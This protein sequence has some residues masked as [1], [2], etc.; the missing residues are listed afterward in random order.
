MF[1]LGE[2]NSLVATEERGDGREGRGSLGLLREVAIGSLGLLRE[3]SLGLLREVE[4][5]G[6]SLLVGTVDELLG[7]SLALPVED[8]VVGDKL[9]GLLEVDDIFSSDLPFIGEIDNVVGGL[10]ELAVVALD[11]S[12][13]SDCS[14]AKD[15]TVTIGVVEHTL[16]DS[17]GGNSVSPDLSVILWRFESLAIV[18]EKTDLLASISAPPLS[19][20][21][22]LVDR[23]R[24]GF[25]TSIL[26]TEA[27]NWLSAT[28]I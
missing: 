12:R 24:V 10:L 15:V 11:K 27:S 7:E 5:P 2:T 8:V 19:S 3:V 14:G 22:S 17:V 13:D 1:L 9:L 25:F 26:S 16:A 4:T 6:L 20:A 28:S 23:F 21:S 18:S